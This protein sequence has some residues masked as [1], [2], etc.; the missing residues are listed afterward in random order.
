MKNLAKSKKGGFSCE[1][2]VHYHGKAGK[3]VSYPVHTH[4]FWQLEL[5]LSGVSEIVSPGG[6]HVFKGGEFVLVPS[7]LPHGFN[8]HEDVEIA[9]AM[10]KPDW[11][12]PAL[13]GGIVAPRGRLA[14]EI[15]ALLAA[16][17]KAPQMPDD[18]RLC[19]ERVL[20]MVMEMSCKTTSS[21][22]PDVKRAQDFIERRIERPLTVA[23]VAKEVGRSA[24]YLSSLFRG[25][26]GM[27]LKRYIAS[28][29]MELV[30]KYLLYTEFSLTDIVVKSGFPDIYAF[31][32]FVKRESGR[33]PRALRRGGA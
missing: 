13:S 24:P 25:G 23:E 18:D 21:V 30:E 6:G 12:P 32:R 10:F 15:A 2:L 26:A 16:L 28:K 1:Y 31:S 7:G 3:G 19:F 8:Y 4:G 20:G 33:S 17:L 14:P 9:T 29:R 11:T 27:S 22:H 5:L